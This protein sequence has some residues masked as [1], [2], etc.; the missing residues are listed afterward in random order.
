MLGKLGSCRYRTYSILLLYTNSLTTQTNNDE[1]VPYYTM[2]PPR[3]QHAP[4]G[5]FISND[6]AASDAYDLNQDA[7]VAPSEHHADKLADPDVSDFDDDFDSAEPDIEEAL[8]GDLTQD[9]SDIPTCQDIGQCEEW[10]PD[11]H[12]TFERLVRESENGLWKPMIKYALDAEAQSGSIIGARY[13]REPGLWIELSYLTLSC[14]HHRVIHELTYGNLFLAA[15]ADAELKGLLEKYHERSK[16]QPIIYARVHVTN[17]GNAMSVQD[18]LR[19]VKWLRRYVSEDSEVVKHE[20]CQKAFWLV[21]REFSKRWKR[22]DTGQ[23]FRRFLATKSDVRSKDRVEVLRKFSERLEARCNAIG[24]MDG[25][26]SPPLQYIGYAARG[27]IRQRQH[28]ACGSSS[29]WLASLVQSLCNKVWGRDRFRMHFFVICPL[30]EEAQGPVAEML[31]TRV[32]GAY[33]HGGGGFCIDIAGKSMESIHFSKL[34]P[35]QRRDRWTEYAVWVDEN[36]PLATNWDA[37]ELLIEEERAQKK[38]QK[39]ER[40]K[41]RKEG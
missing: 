22:E 16:V 17:N 31:L 23:G 8:H 18:A 33:Y 3:R 30:S 29:N 40:K 19:L 15:E 26:L 11:E 36:T 2:T 10:R 35:A 39:K 1:T 28:E 5:D 38:A 7:H 32:P 13:A 14:M 4:L 37:Q 20:K 41:A 6:D 27:D 24:D 25:V 21:D 34:S 12:E 9:E